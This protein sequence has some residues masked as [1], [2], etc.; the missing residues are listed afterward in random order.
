M[1]VPLLLV[2]AALSMALITSEAFGMAWGDSRHRRGTVQIEGA[3]GGSGY[4]AG[5]PEPS[6]LHAIASGLALLGGAGWL[7][8][9]K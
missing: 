9:R 6:S 7:L 1:R 8:R 4:N 5:L 3:S 2:I